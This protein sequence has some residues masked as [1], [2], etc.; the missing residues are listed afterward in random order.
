M[1]LP[2]LIGMEISTDSPA[3]TIHHLLCQALL[4]SW[5][6]KGMYQKEE[7]SFMSSTWSGSIRGGKCSVDVSDWDPSSGSRCS[8]GCQHL[9]SIASLPVR[10]GCLNSFLLFWWCSLMKD[11]QVKWQSYCRVAQVISARLTT[12]SLAFLPTTHFLPSRTLLNRIDAFLCKS[13][14]LQTLSCPLYISI[15][16]NI[17]SMVIKLMSLNH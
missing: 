14:V 12:I 16:V 7:S 13:V 4:G 11:C 8:S 15:K 3:F 5:R 1:Q 10:S 9:Q 6:H 17:N 2:S